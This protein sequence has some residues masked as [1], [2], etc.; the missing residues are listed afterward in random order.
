MDLET[1]HQSVKE[2]TFDASN[3]LERIVSKSA[4]LNDQFK[5][6][7]CAL[8]DTFGFFN[9]MLNERK[10]TVT[11][12]LVDFFNKRQN[13]LHSYKRKAQDAMEHLIRVSKRIK[14]DNVV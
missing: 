7:S 6:T 2:G 14:N 11:K 8:N 5:R 12:D 10:A 3:V 4:D 1:L 13:L 9:T